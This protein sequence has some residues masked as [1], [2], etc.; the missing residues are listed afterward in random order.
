[1][2]LAAR[3]L[4]KNHFNRTFQALSKNVFIRADIALSALETFL[5][6]GL[7]KFTV[8]TYLLTYLCYLE[9]RQVVFS[10]LLSCILRRAVLAV[11]KMSVR[12]SVKRVNCDIKKKIPAHI[13]TPYERSFILVFRQGEW[14]VVAT[15]CT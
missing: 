2:E 5:F 9:H 14:L 13:F 8:L 15:P 12:L 3:T 6:N 10:F 1:V 7:Y 4:A 11:T